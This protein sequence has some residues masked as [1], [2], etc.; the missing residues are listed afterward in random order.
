MLSALPFL[1]F[2]AFG[3]LTD[4]RARRVPNALVLG[5]LGW[6]LVGAL[7]HWSPA[8]SPAAAGLGALTGLACWLPFWL[9]GLL[10]AG[11][12]K[13]FAAGGAWIG[14]SLAWRAALATALVGGLMAFVVLVRDRGFRRTAAETA[15]QYQHAAQLIAT[16][17]LGSTDAVKRTFPYAVPMGLTLAVAALW[18]ELVRQW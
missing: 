3:M 16:A 12:V 15:L 2:L 14:P 1:A 5:M 6:A 13:Y 7:M 11:D 4:V 10:G 9:A 17:D 18:P 8:A